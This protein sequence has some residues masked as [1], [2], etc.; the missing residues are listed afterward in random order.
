MYIL[1]YKYYII[2]ILTRNIFKKDIRRLSNTD[3]LNATKFAC[4]RR[5][6]F[7]PLSMLESKTSKVVVLF[8]SLFC[9]VLC[10]AKSM[11]L[12]PFFFQFRYS[13]AR[14]WEQCF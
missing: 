7:L 12:N 2:Y 6:F 10:T 1:K 3:N 8:L 13:P 5:N 11:H 14:I 9:L 4:F